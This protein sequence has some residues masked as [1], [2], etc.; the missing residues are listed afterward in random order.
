MSERRHTPGPWRVDSD[1][2]GY[3]IEIVGRPTWPC[4]RFGVQGDWDIAKIEE[5]DNDAEA[6]A[7]AR[8]IAAA[9]ELLEALLDIIGD[10]EFGCHRPAYIKARSAIA[11]AVT[12]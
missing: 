2:D 7:N 11:K 6:R 1:N 8:L 3:G 9:P 4:S 10:N 5:L 12:K